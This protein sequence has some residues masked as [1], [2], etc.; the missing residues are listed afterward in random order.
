MSASAVSE[1]ERAAVT[2]LRW[3]E[4][5]RPAP[6]EQF[7]PDGLARD[8][9]AAASEHLREGQ[10]VGIAVGSRGITGLAGVVGL[11]VEAVRGAG[12]APVLIPAMGSH[13]GATAAGQVGVLAELG[14]TEEGLGVPVDA[15]MDVAVVGELS[16]GYRLYTAR[17]ALAC[18]AVIPV[19]RVKPHSDFRGRVES[20]LTKMLTIGLGKEEGASSL[21]RAGFTS[22]DKAL[23]EAAGPVLAALTV[24]FGVALLEDAWHRLHRAEVVPGS[25]IV[26]RDAELLAQAW[27]LFGTLPYAEVDLLVLKEMG[28]TISGAGMDPNI[29]GRFPAGQLPCPTSVACLVTLDLRDDSGGNAIGVGVADVV[30]ER[31]R[32]KVNWGYT[33]ANARA[34]KSLGGARLPLVAGNDLDAVAIALSSLVGEQPHQAAAVAMANTLTVNHFAATGPL[35]KQAQSAGYEVVSDDLE[36]RFDQAGRLEGIGGVEFFPGGGEG[37]APRHAVYAGGP[38][39]GTGI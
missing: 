25:S 15:S 27:E 32:D 36:A 38:E 29:T 5:I 26:E 13:G 3:T 19:N 37:A 8:L 4:L 9:R 28:K 17:S 1:A 16:S 35:V 7:D 31:L 14:V 21:H 34:S 12:A 24:P 2:E 11:V 10:R 39:G 23:P 20:G 6:P 22:F 30:T 18:D 33:Y